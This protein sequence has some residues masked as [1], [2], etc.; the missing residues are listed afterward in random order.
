VV[1]LALPLGYVAT[2]Q[3]IKIDLHLGQSK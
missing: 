2:K 3:Q 1:V